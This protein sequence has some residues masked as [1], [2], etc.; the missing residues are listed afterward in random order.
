MGNCMK[1]Y[2]M[3]IQNEEYE[4]MRSVSSSK[5]EVVKPSD[6]G[7]KRKM[8]RFKLREEN[9]VDHREGNVGS[10]SGNG[11]VRVRVLLTQK[12]LNQILNNEFN[13]NSVEQL[14]RAMELRSRK[15]SRVRTCDGDINGSWRPALESIPEDH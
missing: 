2:R 6:D 1:G 12:E 8:V 7:G 4:G 15:V 14:L 13:D 11:V 5:C 9:G 3:V 10:R